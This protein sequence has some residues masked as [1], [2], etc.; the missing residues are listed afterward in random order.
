M[1]IRKRWEMTVVKRKKVNFVSQVES[2]EKTDL[3]KLANILIHC[4]NHLPNKVCDLLFNR[5]TISR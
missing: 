1:Q 4:R 5:L 2:T 3:H